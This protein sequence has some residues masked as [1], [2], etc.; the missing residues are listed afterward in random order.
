MPREYRMIITKVERG[1]AG[2]GK[3]SADAYLYSIFMLGNRIS[4]VSTCVKHCT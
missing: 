4:I 1:I 3:Y 2:R